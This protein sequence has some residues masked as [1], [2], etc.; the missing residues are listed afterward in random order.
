[1]EWYSG[2]IILAKNCGIAKLRF[3]MSSKK[4]QNL[5]G[6]DLYKRMIGG[7]IILNYFIS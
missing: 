4:D 5:E 3:G 6:I 7:D 2:K 1:M